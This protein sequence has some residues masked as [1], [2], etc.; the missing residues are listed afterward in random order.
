MQAFLES[1]LA[2]G[3]AVGLHPRRRRIKAR[4]NSQV[5]I[6]LQGFLDDTERTLEGAKVK[7]RQVKRTPVAAIFF[8]LVI[9]ADQHVQKRSAQVAEA[10]VVK[11]VPGRDVELIVIEQDA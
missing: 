6:P 5:R 1:A 8:L 11:F 10:P 9:G 3:S 4:V 7:L 2:A